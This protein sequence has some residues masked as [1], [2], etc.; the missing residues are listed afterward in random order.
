MDVNSTQSPGIFR[1]K[2]MIII[3]IVSHFKML[4]LAK[5]Y[6]KNL[7]LH[8]NSLKIH[9]V[10]DNLLVC[11]KKKVYKNIPFLKIFMINCS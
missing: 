8:F 4:I 2:M 10:L 6:A 11:S 3:L 7:L 5:S 9:N 1:L